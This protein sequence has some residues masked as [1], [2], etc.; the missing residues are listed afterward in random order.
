[1]NSRLAWWALGSAALLGGCT[2]D[3][4][5]YDFSGAPGGAGGA[6]TGA[7]SSGGSGGSGNAS[8]GGAGAIGNASNGGGGNTATGG[9]SMGGSAVLV[10]CGASPCDVA[11]GAAC[12]V[13]L[14]TEAATCPAN[15]KCGG[16]DVKVECDGPADCPGEACC[17]TT[18]GGDYD[19]VV[20]KGSCGGNDQ[21]VCQI[22]DDSPCGGNT[23]QADIPGGYGI[24]Q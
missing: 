1:M 17:A 24:C 4:D 20:C 9:S 5:A 23:C 19:K 7:G 2:G 11:S 10:D 16:N 21:L 18:K 15:G 14:D 3:F 8:N 13:D 22:G 12:C 6:G